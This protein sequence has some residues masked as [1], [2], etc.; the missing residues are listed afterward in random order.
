M[1]AYEFEREGVAC[2]DKSVGE[3][4]MAVPVAH[5]RMREKLGIPFYPTMSRT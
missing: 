2:I 3:P 1:M 5:R 4:H